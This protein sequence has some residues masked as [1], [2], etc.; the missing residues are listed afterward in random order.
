MARTKQT[1]RRLGKGPIIRRSM[2]LGSKQRQRRSELNA[3]HAELRKKVALFPN[4]YID[5]ERIQLAAT[6][7]VVASEA[8]P[9]APARV[10]T[11]VF[12]LPRRGRPTGSP[13]LASS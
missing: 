3:S 10:A 5:D 8:T 11:R 13:S 1:A 12:P 9:E 7:G 6:L 2:L 4:S